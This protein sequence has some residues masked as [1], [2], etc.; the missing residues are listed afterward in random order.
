MIL[1][2]LLEVNSQKILPI[3]E[4]CIDEPIFV[5]ENLLAK[6]N[7]TN[8]DINSLYFL[9][10]QNINVFNLSSAFYKD[11]CYHFDSPINK[12]ITL[13]D[14]I[15]LYYPNVTLCESGCHIKGVNLTTFRALCECKLNN[16][17]S[18]NIFEDNLLFQSQFGEIQDLISKTNIEVLKCYKDFYNKKYFLSCF[19]GFFILCLI[20]I[21]IIMTILYFNKSLLLI[22]KY[23]FGITGK[24]ILHLTSSKLIIS[25]ENALILSNEPPKKKRKKKQLVKETNESESIKNRPDLNS[26][27]LKTEIWIKKS[28]F[29]DIN[30]KG[31]NEGNYNMILSNMTG[32]NIQSTLRLP[33]YNLKKYS[34]RTFERQK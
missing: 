11:I 12:D 28:K 15:K 2:S 5:E 23:I 20:I 30:S 16:I 22:R 3:N 8:I 18:N 13:K 21:Q 7:N 1:Y 25:E 33:N 17:M 10:N 19:G 32:K 9:T 34:K 24:Y 31:K 29:T 27:K 26:N 14:R 4:F 6:I